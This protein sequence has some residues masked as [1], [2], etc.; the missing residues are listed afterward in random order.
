M[1]AAVSRRGAIAVSHDR[2]FAA[3]S[4]G[5]TTDIRPRATAVLHMG[6]WAN[7]GIPHPSIAD[8]QACAAAT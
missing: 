8:S 4:Q 2:R 1:A 7:E 5:D 6:S 3:D